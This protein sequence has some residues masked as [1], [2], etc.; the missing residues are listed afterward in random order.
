MAPQTVVSTVESLAGQ[1]ELWW[2]VQRAE[3]TVALRAVCW[4]GTR[5]PTR[6]AW[7]GEK[8]AAHSADWKEKLLAAGWVAST[9]CLT[10]ANWARQTAGWTAATKGPLTVAKSDFH[11][12]A[13]W[14]VHLAVA[15]AWHWAGRWERT[16]AD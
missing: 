5:A 10:A 15:T 9:G 12:A 7:W 11:S 2:A 1:R 4:A 13:A 6:A 14:D 3:S 8:T 16:T